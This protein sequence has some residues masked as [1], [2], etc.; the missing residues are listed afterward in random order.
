MIYLFSYLC[1]GVILF[2]INLLWMKLVDKVDTQTITDIIGETNR[3]MRSKTRNFFYDV[4]NWCI[5]YPVAL[6]GAISVWPIFVYLRIKNWLFPT[7]PR[8]ESK[9]FC[10]EHTD[11][12]QQLT[13]EEIEAKEV[14][15]DPLGAAPNVA[16]GHLN[17]KWR[18]F[19]NYK[20]PKESVW[21]FSTIW[22][23]EF[24]LEDH[25]EGYVLVNGEN[26][27]KHFFTNWNF[28]VNK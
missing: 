4:F 27:G 12:R 6:C 16:F 21:M 14:V 5:F 7:P 13:V 22:Q 23:D 3:A 15:F 2:F 24:G 8:Q 26:I 20:L 9:E 28:I 19:L 17:N 1:I 18:E 11:L 10:I 25:F